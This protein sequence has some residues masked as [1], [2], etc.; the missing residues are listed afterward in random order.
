VSQ[1]PIYRGAFKSGLTPER[2]AHELG[3][4]YA[5]D[6]DYAVKLVIIMKRYHLG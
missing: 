6:P 3:A 5:T 2:F 4:H 1:S